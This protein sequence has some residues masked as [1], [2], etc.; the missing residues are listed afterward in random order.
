MSGNNA[1]VTAPIVIQQPPAVVVQTSSTHAASRG[2]MNSSTY[3]EASESQEIELNCRE[4]QSETQETDPNPQEEEQPRGEIS[5]TQPPPSNLVPQ[6]LT[7]LPNTSPKINSP[8]PPSVILSEER[9]SSTVYQT[10]EQKSTQ[11]PSVSCAQNT[12]TT[13]SKS[14][15]G[16]GDCCSLS[17]ENKPIP[18]TVERKILVRTVNTPVV[19]KTAES[20]TDKKET[21]EVRAKIKI[22]AN[23]S[24]LRENRAKIRVKVAQP[25]SNI[26]NDSRPNF[27]TMTRSIIRSQTLSTIYRSRA[28]VNTKDGLNKSMDDI[29]ERREDA[30]LKRRAER[31]AKLRAE[32]MNNPPILPH[33]PSPT[34][35]HMTSAKTMMSSLEVRGLI[36]PEVS[37]IQK[38]VQ[39]APKTTPIPSPSNPPPSTGG[40][41]PQSDSHSG[42]MKLESPS[43]TMKPGSFM[44]YH[45][46]MSPQES[47]SRVSNVEQIDELEN[48]IIDLS[49]SS[50]A[51]AMEET[52]QDTPEESDKMDAEKSSYRD[53]SPSLSSRTAT[54]T[55]SRSSSYTASRGSRSGSWTKSSTLSKR[56]RSRSR[57]HNTTSSSTTP[58]RGRKSR[59]TRHRHSPS[60]PSM[61][62]QS[63][64]RSPTPMPSQNP[65][66]SRKKRK[67][68]L[69]SDSPVPRK[70]KNSSTDDYDPDYAAFTEVPPEIRNTE[71]FCYFGNPPPKD[72]ER[73]PQ[74][75]AASRPYPDRERDRDRYVQQP[76]PNSSRYPRTNFQPSHSTHGHNLYEH[77]SPRNHNSYRGSST[78]GGGT[79]RNRYNYSG[80]YSTSPH[81]NYNNYPPHKSNYNYNYNNYPQQRQPYSN[82]YPH[83]RGGYNNHQPQRSSYTPTHPRPGYNQYHQKES[84][85]AKRSSK[86]EGNSGKPEKNENAGFGAFYRK[87]DDEW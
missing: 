75:Y 83:Q 45:E 11:S 2:Q 43:I 32:A 50:D 23:E 27:T 54:A 3:A 44:H 55:P 9:T 39:D 4:P 60:S 24:L 52:T 84:Y 16:E 49:D 21:V 8:L 57:S 74:S 47:V 30:R 29:F 14:N 87:D 25:Q 78:Q 59:R 67:G 56:S 69:S 62:S 28:A 18:S 76:R 37:L 33:P 12:D 82:N 10:T 68:K 19:S 20:V 31:Q 72:R 73:T 1:G 34:T 42:F 71:A 40:D 46:D 65:R 15:K 80:S 79:N 13:D 22:Q 7:P 64:S 66:Y 53:T 48:E 41:T 38:R 6:I 35:Q 86:H 61:Q 81:H 77:N 51:E 70:Y 5:A 36:R 58:T 26:S 63:L 85:S 17:E